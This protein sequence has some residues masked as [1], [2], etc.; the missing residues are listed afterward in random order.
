VDLGYFDVCDPGTASVFA[1][2]CKNAGG[3]CPSLPNPYRPLGAGEL[4]GTGFDIWKQTSFEKQ[5]TAAGATRWLESQAPVKGGSEFTIRFAI[6]DTG[7]Q[8][9]D[10][11]VLIDNFQWIAAPGVSVTTKPVPTPM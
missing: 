8:Q 4:K 5:P 10:S 11:T 9:Y 3:S 7:N 2:R 6:W 1:Y